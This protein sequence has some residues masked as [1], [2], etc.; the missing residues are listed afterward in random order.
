MV[1]SQSSSITKLDLYRFLIKYV[2]NGNGQIDQKI[3][4]KILEAFIYCLKYFLEY[5]MKRKD[6]IAQ[7]E[8][9]FNIHFLSKKSI[10]TQNPFF[11]HIS[12]MLSD[13]IDSNNIKFKE[14]EL[15]KIKL[16]S[17]KPFNFIN[18][19]I[20]E[21]SKNYKDCLDL[22]LEE[23]TKKSKEKVF[24]WIDNKFKYFNGINNKNNDD[25]KNYENLIKAIIDIIS[26]LVKLNKD[27][28]KRIVSK[29]FKND[30]MLE[31]YRKLK[32]LP[33][34]QFEFL[35][36]LLYQK[37]EQIKEEEENNPKENGEEQVKNIDLFQLYMSNINNNNINLNQEKIIREH[38]DK[39]FLEQIKLL[40][41]L[42]R[43]NEVIA[44]LK[45]NIP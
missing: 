25:K 29:Y 33:S 44:Y 39:L 40:V 8:D 16:A 42:N 21:L 34:E 23:E 36:L 19:K 37:F 2:T 7:N 4:Q 20:A 32:Y 28:T 9:K 31:A 43:R 27:K 41:K 30:E 17:G 18:I 12:N 11:I 5:P 15:F 45:K 24:D 10:D 22:F 1:E 38:F 13:L 6:L 14:E 35:E 26:E 3:H